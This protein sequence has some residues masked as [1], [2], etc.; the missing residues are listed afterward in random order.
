M[1]G[2]CRDRLVMY[3]AK[4]FGRCVAL[5]EIVLWCTFRRSSV[6]VWHL[7][8]SSCGLL[9]GGVQWA[10]HVCSVTFGGGFQQAFVEDLGCTLRRSCGVL[11][12]GLQWM[13]EFLVTFLF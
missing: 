4:E 12:G 5:A 9:C 6:G 13:Y 2:T 1:Y 7:R 10:Y 11:C 8:R 3:F